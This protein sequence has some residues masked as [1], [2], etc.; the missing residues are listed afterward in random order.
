MDPTAGCP[1][2]GTIDARHA[3]DCSRFRAAASA[4]RE[5]LFHRPCSALPAG[6]RHCAHGHTEDCPNPSECELL[7]APG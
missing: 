3:D 2:C 7:D 5:G 6:H 4:G 1:E